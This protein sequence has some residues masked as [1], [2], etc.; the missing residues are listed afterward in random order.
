[1]TPSY[2]LP[3]LMAEWETLSSTEPFP[4]AAAGMLLNTLNRASTNASAEAQ[5]V[6]IC[7]CRMCA[8]AAETNLGRLRQPPQRYMRKG[9]GNKMALSKPML[10]TE[11]MGADGM[12]TGNAKN[13]S[14]HQPK[15]PR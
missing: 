6:G 8:A 3:M 9:P 7:T 4:M 11:P 13:N 2:T 12:D 5:F 14:P 1:M 15:G 10:E